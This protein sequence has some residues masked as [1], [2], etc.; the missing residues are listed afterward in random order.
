[1]AGD[2]SAWDLPYRVCLILAQKKKIKNGK[3]DQKIIWNVQNF[4]QNL[5]WDWRQYAP[6]AAWSRVG[7]R[8]ATLHLGVLLLGVHLRRQGPAEATCSLW[9][10]PASS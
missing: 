7:Q 8:E 1:M 5:D 6:V 4:C 2:N 10:L 3:L 9:T